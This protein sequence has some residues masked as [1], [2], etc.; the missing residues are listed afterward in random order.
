MMIGNTL[1]STTSWGVGQGYV[2]MS[3]C[4]T[5]FSPSE[6]VCTAFKSLAKGIITVD[7][8]NLLNINLT[9]YFLSNENE[10][11]LF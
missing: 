6:T 9:L 7:L 3:V 10:G 1:T 11:E 5:L 8:C 4:M 2:F